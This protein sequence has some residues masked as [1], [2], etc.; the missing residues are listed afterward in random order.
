MKQK[1]IP[2]PVRYG[3]NLVLTIALWAVLFGLIQS[4]SITNYWS[5]IL[6]TVGINIILA[7]SLNN[8]VLPRLL[9]RS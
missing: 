5:G 2:M 9:A 8:Y 3:I 1:R 7:V 6:V 4:G